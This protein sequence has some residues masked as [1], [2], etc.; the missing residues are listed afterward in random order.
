MR[1]TPWLQAEPYRVVK[2]LNLMDAESLNLMD[3]KSKYGDDYGDFIIPF[4]GI[5]LICI[6]SAG[7]RDV[8]WEHVS[9]S[10]KNR[11]P[12]WYELQFIKEIFWDDDETV[13]QLHVSKKL[14]ISIHPH[15]LHLWR[16]IG[17]EIPLPPAIAV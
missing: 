1:P 17:Q 5:I 14:H 2:S 3:A 15:V 12:N 6:V 13:M 11:C 7:D 9:V 4:R 16:P 10:L 8:P